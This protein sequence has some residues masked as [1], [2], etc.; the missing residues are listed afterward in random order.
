MEKRNDKTDR[1]PSLTMQAAMIGASIFFFVIIGVLIFLMVRSNRTTGD[2]LLVLIVVIILLGFAESVLI[3]GYIDVK[4][5]NWGFYKETARQEATQEFNLAGDLTLIFKATKEWLAENN[6]KIKKETPYS[7]I[8]SY[9]G[10]YGASGFIDAYRRR[11]L[12]IRFHSD[13]S[14]NFISIYEKVSR[15]G[16]MMGRL[17]ENEVKGLIHHLK[18]NF[19]EIKEDITT[20]SSENRA[21]KPI[22]LCNFCGQK[23]PYDV[24]YCEHCGASLNT[25]D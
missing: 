8:N 2:P 3:A 11:W 19:Q 17:I 12:E 9:A 4:N 22:K 15:L 10:Y 18:S 23:L 7:Y 21:K 5:P 1:R 16:M 24:Y 6:F 14:G 25:Q 13:S 20:E